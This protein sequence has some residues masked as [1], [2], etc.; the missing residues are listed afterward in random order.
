MDM[1]MIRTKLGERSYDGEIT[2]KEALAVAE[3]LGVEPAGFAR[4]LSGMNIKIVQCQLS[5][6][7]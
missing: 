1:D 6:F 2:C 3:E 5:C 4:I 7:P